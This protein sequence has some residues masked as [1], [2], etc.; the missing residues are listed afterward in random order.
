MSSWI[1]RCAASSIR[2][3]GRAV[4]SADAFG[5]RVN[6]NYKGREKFST[7]V[8]GLATLLMAGFLLQYF[9]NQMT[10]MVFRE[11]T[12]INSG[13]RFTILIIKSITLN[14]VFLS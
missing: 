6:L 8:G 12:V 11:S 13:K 9:Y 2:M 4:K 3:V 10:K 1:E 14:L 5:V 7:F